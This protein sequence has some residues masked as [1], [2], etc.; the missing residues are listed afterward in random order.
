[1]GTVLSCPLRCLERRSRLCRANSGSRNS[2]RAWRNPHRPLATRYLQ[3][4]QMPGEH[5]ASPV[6]PLCFKAASRCMHAPTSLWRYTLD[7]VAPLLTGRLPAGD[8]PAAGFVAHEQ[9]V[10]LDGAP[11]PILPKVPGNYMRCRLQGSFPMD[12]ADSSGKA[13][14]VSVAASALE[15]LHCKQCSPHICPPS[16]QLSGP[17]IAPVTAEAQSALAVAVSTA[18]GWNY[19]QMTQVDESFSM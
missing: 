10:H 8:L 6:W 18:P 1:M 5:I 14:Y 2:C 19:G 16:V 12:T 13:L 15:L 9:H 17:S 7:R 4:C 3:R 11:P